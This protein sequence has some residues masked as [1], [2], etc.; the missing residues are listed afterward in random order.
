[1][2][3]ERFEK[4]STPSYFFQSATQKYL[5][6][7]KHLRG[8]KILDIA[9]GTGYGTNIMFERHPEFKFF[10]CDI[11][12]QAIKYA[13]N[14]YKQIQFKKEDA[15]STNYQDSFFDTVVS[16]ETLE[17]LENGQNFIK[18]IKR[19][20]KPD[21]ILICSTPNRHFGER[22]GSTPEKPLNPHHVSLY[23]HD[24]FRELLSSSFKDVKIFGQTETG[25]NFF[26][27]F[28][29]FYRFYRKIKPLIL[30]AI[31]RSSSKSEIVFPEK[32]NPKFEPKPF[33]KSAYYL[34]AIASDIPI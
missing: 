19:I 12:D 31:T 17:H 34:I 20:L 15:Y 25:A 3:L 4:G 10:G 8:T 16:F 30:P 13:Q 32:L 6:A 2:T 11:D 5:F 23:Y 28:P 22:L 29:I 26:Y 18:E 14:N 21:G 33:W 27:K 7:S 24:D 9:C 1:M